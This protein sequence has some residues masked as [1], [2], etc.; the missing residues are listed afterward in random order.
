MADLRE[1]LARAIAAE[2]GCEW[3]PAGEYAEQ[4]HDHW[5]ALADAALNVVAGW[6]D[7]QGRRG[8]RA[9][10]VHRSHAGWGHAAGHRYAARQLCAMAKDRQ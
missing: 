7:E 6:L 5:I 3:P 4:M 10:H 1:D 8:D 2:S 9:A